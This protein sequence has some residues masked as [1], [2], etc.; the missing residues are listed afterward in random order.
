M[1]VNQCHNDGYEI[2]FLVLQSRIFSC[3]SQFFWPFFFLRL[4]FHRLLLVKKY[5]VFNPQRKKITNKM[6]C[7][8]NVRSI[9]LGFFV[10]IQRMHFVTVVFFKHVVL[11]FGGTTEKLIHY[12]YQ[13]RWALKL[14]GKLKC[15]LCIHFFHMRFL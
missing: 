5:I 1:Y 3:A 15:V 11:L 8:L 14:I 12:L 6:P 4:V 9:A 10:F 13:N 2:F 7:N